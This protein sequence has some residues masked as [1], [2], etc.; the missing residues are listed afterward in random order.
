MGVLEHRRKLHAQAGEIVDVEE[1][2]VV[3]LVLG[4]AMKC[5]APELRADQRVQFTPV[6]VERSDP[7]RDARRALRV[8]A[9]SS[10]NSAFSSCARSAIS[11]AIAAG[12]RKR[13][14]MT[15]QGGAL[16]GRE[17]SG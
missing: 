9:A 8:G 12:R 7:R 4:H 3:D 16:R 11:G 13:S 10:A 5:D 1:A 15:V 6:A 2:A 14:A 17:S